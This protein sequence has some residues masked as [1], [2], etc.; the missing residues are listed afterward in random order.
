MADNS[1]TTL[2]GTERLKREKRNAKIRL[3]RERNKLYKLIS[4]RDTSK[5]TIR[6]YISRIK[7]EFR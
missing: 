6:R 1:G 7:S 3:T 4:A 2:E 5:N